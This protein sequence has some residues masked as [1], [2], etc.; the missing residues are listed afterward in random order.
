MPPML[1]V[2][3]LGVSQSDR[4]VWLCE[5]LGIPYELKLYQRDPGLAPAAY[6]ALTPYG[7]AP[8]IT[9]GALALGESGAIIDYIIAKYGEGRLAVAADQPNFT[10]Y[11]FWFH[12][13]NGTMMAALMADLTVRLATGA[14]PPAAASFITD[15][16]DRSYEIVEERLGEVPFF[17]GD[18]FTAADIMML[19]PLTSMRMFNPRDFTPYPHLR[20]Y[21]GKIAERPAFI[22]AMAKAEPGKPIQL[23]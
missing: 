2:H 14:A 21:L 1:T 11:L 22:A 4:I 7:T 10:D 3:H 16:I 13:S 12:F 19:F 5:E 9:D 18:A 8:A 15:R 17:A 20:A 23:I 6:K